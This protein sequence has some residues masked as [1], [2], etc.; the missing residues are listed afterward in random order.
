MITKKIIFYSILFALVIGQPLFSQKTDTGAPENQ[1]DEKT[2]TVDS[3]NTQSPVLNQTVST[4]SVWDAIRM[5]LVLG[6][7]L[8]VI[9]LLFFLLKKAG[10]P[11]K[12]SGSIIN[13]IATKNL[14]NNSAVHI[15]KVGN[16]YFFVGAG[17]GNIRLL[18]EITDR[19][20]LDQFKLESSGSLT[21]NRSF[22]DILKGVFRGSGGLGNVDKERSGF[23]K[24]QR[25][26]LK[27]M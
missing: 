8:G 26:R 27:K 4:F 21:Q 19:E 1:I 7:V 11:V 16:Q 14:T 22:S 13:V 23:L 17:D 9:Y 10:R 6:G 18:S 3:T 2:L 20:T 15:L 5:V 24:Q 12:D 25:E